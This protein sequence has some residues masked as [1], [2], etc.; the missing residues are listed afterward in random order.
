MQNSRAEYLCGIVFCI[1]FFSLIQ[2]HP[3]LCA[4]V[5]VCGSYVAAL[6]EMRQWSRWSERERKS[7][8]ATFLKSVC[9]LV[10]RV[11]VQRTGVGVCCS[12]SFVF[13]FVVPYS[14][15]V[16]RAKLTPFDSAFTLAVAH[17]C[18]LSSSSRNFLPRL[19]FPF[20][21]LLS[22]SPF[23]S[24]VVLFVSSST[25]LLATTRL[26]AFFFFGRLL[27]P[28]P[29]LLH[30]PD[31]DAAGDVDSL[32]RERETGGGTSEHRYPERERESSS[33]QERRTTKEKEDSGR[34][35]MSR[36][37][38]IKQENA[39]KTKGALREEAKPTQQGS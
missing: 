37:E 24:P 23:C 17:N 32:Q 27:R 6:Q 18:D 33:A 35:E 16:G 13:F 3:S 30:N 21:C 11:C 14:V 39:Q 26:L 5:C 7:N 19:F 34:T 10:T 2:L 31:I 9:H 8:K 22:V 15:G 38:K 20:V 4:H 25:A 28:L 1:V 36:R 29:L 12:F